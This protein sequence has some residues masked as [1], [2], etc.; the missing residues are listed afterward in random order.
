MRK[1]VGDDTI[2]EEPRTVEKLKNML[3]NLNGIGPNDEKPA[4]VN[5]VI[6]LAFS[7]IFL[8]LAYMLISFFAQLFTVIMRKGILRSEKSRNKE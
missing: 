4:D 3:L 2:L 1:T 7:K 6:C 8:S 5:L